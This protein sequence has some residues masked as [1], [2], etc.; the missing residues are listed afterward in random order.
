M[1]VPTASSSLAAL[2]LLTAFFVAGPPRH[3]REPSGDFAA[4]GHRGAIGSADRLRGVT[5]STRRP[6]DN[7]VL[8]S[9]EGVRASHLTLVPFAFQRGVRSPDIRYNPSGRWFSESDAGIRALADSAHAMGMRVILKP[10]VWVGRSESEDDWRGNIGFS[11]EAEWRI[12]ESGY[13]A[14][15]LHHAALAAD[16]GAEVFVVGTELRRA[17]VERASFWRE[18]IADVRSVFPGRV[19]YAANWWE[20]YE[21]VDFWDALDFVGVQAYFPVGAAGETSVAALERGWRP[22]LRALERVSRETGKPILFTEI[23]YRSHPGAAERPWEWPTRE[24]SSAD[25]P[26][27]TTQAN[28]YEAFFKSAWDRRWFAGAIVWCWYGDTA[29]TERGQRIGFTPQGKPAEKV[30]ASWFAR[31]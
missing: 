15:I 10:H 22:H 29:P 2:G 18:L 1:R 17:A 4:A 11:T 3:E 14:Y 31:R 20:E 23:G 30:I 26:D 24:Q 8:R 28:L 16:V 19:T 13:R 12:W 25:R 6:P 7:G 27:Y 21:Q 5:L 9:I